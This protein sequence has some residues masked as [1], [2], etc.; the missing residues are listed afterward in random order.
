MKATPLLKKSDAGGNDSIGM[1]HP[2]KSMPFKTAINDV[3]A[4]LRLQNKRYLV[5]S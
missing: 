5:D 3:T 2:R 1:D 4:T